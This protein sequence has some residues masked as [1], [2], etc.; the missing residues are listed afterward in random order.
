MSHHDLIHPLKK[1]TLG[2]MVAERLR[3][4]LIQGSYQPGEQLNEV[5]LASRFGVSRGPVREGLQQLVHEGLL[6]S[7]PHRGV[8]VPKM[9]D[10]DVADIYRARDAIERAALKAVLEGEHRVEVTD[11]LE[12]IVQTMRRAAGARRWAEVIDQDMRFHTELVK[13]AGSS[14]LSR[15]YGL[16][17]DETRACLTMTIDNPG[18]E[19]LVSQHEKLLAVLRLGDEDA[20]MQELSHHFSDSVSS[21]SQRTK[22]SPRAGQAQAR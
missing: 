17:L 5:E 1:P 8:F 22:V 14:R 7:E 18:R 10:D 16:L 2:S 19:E 20:A 9:D 13:G 11:R 12:A 21:I 15:M 4:L 3:E 6:R